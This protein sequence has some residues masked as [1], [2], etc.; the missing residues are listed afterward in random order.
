MLEH[1]CEGDSIF[2]SS[3]F[4]AFHSDY[5]PKV[6]KDANL[7]VF[8]HSFTFRVELMMESAVTVIKKNFQH[9]L[10]FSPITSKILL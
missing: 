3:F 7:H 10:S 9:N 2:G 6:M 4:G 1:C 8:I 5:I